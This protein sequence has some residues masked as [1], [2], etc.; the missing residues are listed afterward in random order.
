VRRSW[1]NQSVT[2]DSCLPFVSSGIWAPTIRFH[3]GT[4]YVV[5]TLV[6][7]DRSADDPSRWDNVRQCQFR[8]SIRAANVLGRL[9]SR[10][11]THTTH[12]HGPTHWP[13]TSLAMTHLLSGMLTAKPTSWELMPGMF[14]KSIT[15]TAS[16]KILLTLDQPRYPA[17]RGKP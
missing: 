1:S 7:D 17:S 11:R 16:L 13:L 12:S 5:T 15:P 6:D 3:E 9:S 8:T 4:F 14:C 2:A 10:P